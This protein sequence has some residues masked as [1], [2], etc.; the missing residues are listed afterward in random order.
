MNS[1]WAEIINDYKEEDNFSGL[2]EGIK[3]I[4]SIDAWETDKDEEEGNV[5]AKVVVTK[6]NEIFVIYI[7]NGARLDEY[8]QEKI[9]ESMENL[10]K[11]YI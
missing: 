1:K 4:I 8:A 9:K 2:E 3:A 7:D 10:K 6:H 5:I 11:E